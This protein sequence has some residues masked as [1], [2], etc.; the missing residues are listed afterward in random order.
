[1]EPDSA[2]T[3]PIERRIKLLRRAYGR[4]LGRR[5]TL[6]EAAAMMRAAMLTA[7][8]ESAASDPSISPNDFVRLDGAAHRARRDMLALLA[9]NARPAGRPSLDAYLA[10]KTAGRAVA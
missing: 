9:R 1:M 8:A 7:K 4:G 10:E 2:S 3:A 5:P 6:I